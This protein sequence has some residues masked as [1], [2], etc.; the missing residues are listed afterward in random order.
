MKRFAVVLL[1]LVLIFVLSTTV[2]ASS[3]YLYVDAA[4][5][6][7][8]SPD[9]PA[10]Q[11]AAYAGAASGTFVNMAESAIPCNAGTANFEI[12]DEVVYSFGDLGKRLSFI[13]WI[14][15][16][17]LESLAGV[18]KIGLINVWDGESMDFY[19]D[20][21]GQTWLEPTRWEDY[22]AD[23]DGQTD[24]VIGVAGMAWWG[25]YGVNTPAALEADL[26]AWGQARESWEFKADLRGNISSIEVY[27]KPVRLTK[28]F[29]GCAAGAKNHGQFVSCISKKTNELKKAGVI[30]GEEKGYIQNCAS[31]SC[32]PDCK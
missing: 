24:G 9:Y 29:D 32:F 10:W 1:G 18:F 21:Y 17:T 4:P 27:R 15:G 25:A 7:Y 20:Y 23:G 14:P 13:Y 3:V 26:T 12:E 2:M 31:Q 16:E 5:N 6:A 11:T 30:T 8:G 28:L 19:K 22:D